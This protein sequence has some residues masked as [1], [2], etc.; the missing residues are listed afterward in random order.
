[1]DTLIR[2]IANTIIANLQNTSML[3]LFNGEMGIALFLYRYAHM[4]KQNLY[5]EIAD[6]LIEDVYALINKEMKPDLKNGFCGIGL[7]IKYLIDEMFLDGYIEEFLSEIDATLLENVAKAFGNEL[8]M[9][10]PVFSSGIYLH[11]RLAG[12][13]V[14]EREKKWTI[15]CYKTGI[16]L[17]EEKMAEVQWKPQLALLDS[18]LFTYIEFYNGQ[19]GEPD[20]TESFFNVLLSLSAKAIEVRHFDTCDLYLFLQIYARLPDRIKAQYQQLEKQIENIIQTIPWNMELW[21]D[22]LWWSFIY[23][24]RF[25]IPEESIELYIEQ[26]LDNYPFE[27]E[28]IN[29]RLASLG[30]FLC[31]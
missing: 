7:G 25:P 5:E 11:A 13:N 31:S 15:L 1:M 27:L 28:N 3:G 29:G 30:L 24:Y 22:L 6:G 17:F 10:D 18:M 19:I 20:K 12:H 14:T 21:N 4:S 8:A 26:V 9:P 2:K 23:G 16:S